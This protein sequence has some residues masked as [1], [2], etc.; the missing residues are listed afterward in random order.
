MNEISG[1]LNCTVGRRTII[2]QNWWVDYGAWCGKFQFI[3]LLK[4]ILLAWK[5]CF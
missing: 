3:I 1:G 4:T 2:I 5:Y